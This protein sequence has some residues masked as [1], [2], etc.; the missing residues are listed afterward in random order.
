MTAFVW[1]MLV[2][3]AFSVIV[4]VA[5]L[6]AGTLPTPSKFTMAGDAIIGIGF[7]AW[8]IVLLARA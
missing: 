1:T 2:I 7:M 3:T 5:C 8:A 6:A 4:K